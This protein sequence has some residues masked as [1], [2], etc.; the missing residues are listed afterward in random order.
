[1]K[2]NLGSC[3]RHEPGF[4]SVDLREADFVWDLNITPW[5]WDDNSVE[6]IKAWDVC[7]HLLSRIGF[8]NECWRVLQKGGQLH[9]TTP[10]AAKGGGFFQDPTHVTPWTINSLKYFCVRVDGSD[11]LERARFHRHYGITARF[12]PIYIRETSYQDTPLGPDCA[13]PD[14]VY[15]LDVMLEALK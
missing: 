15:K 8:I 6:H 12:K 5:P 14:P 13:M 1:M 10:N 11:S 2:L 9:I 4:L 7:E 3:N